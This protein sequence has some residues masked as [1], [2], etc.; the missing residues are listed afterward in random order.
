MMG[1]TADSAM[2]ELCRGSRT[3]PH[4]K[5]IKLE[6]IDLTLDET[7]SQSEQGPNKLPPLPPPVIHPPDLS[8]FADNHKHIEIRELLGCL[9]V[10]ELR[11][12]AK[13]TKSEHRGNVCTQV[14]QL[15]SIPFIFLHSAMT[16]YRRYSAPRRVRPPCHFVRL[17]QTRE[18]RKAAFRLRSHFPQS[19]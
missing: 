1:Q 12:L 7:S 13:V 2:E 11:D 17:C 16:S 19:Q 8:V 3:T 15:L 6:V 10:P 14:I 9:T 4:Y 18:Q 5:E